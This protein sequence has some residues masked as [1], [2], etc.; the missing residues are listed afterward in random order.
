MG[1]LK[2]ILNGFFCVLISMVLIH[3]LVYPTFYHEGNTFFMTSYL[4]CSTSS[5]FGIGS[6]LKG[7]N[8]LP[9][10]VNSFLLELTLFRRGLNG[11][12][13]VAAPESVSILLK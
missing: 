1:S 2:I 8:L 5:S 9:E 6:T 3:L 11:K 13:R 12:M 10:G 7:K 4:L